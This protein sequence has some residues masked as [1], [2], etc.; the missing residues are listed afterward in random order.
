MAGKHGPEGAVYE[1]QV[2]PAVRKALRKMDPSTRTGILRV[3]GN[4][5]AIPRP[6]GVVQLKDR[7]GHLRLRIGDYRVIYTVDDET[8]L[9]TVAVA[10]HRREVYR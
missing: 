10:G 7:R 9:V 1:V 6:L 4:L 8:R 3:I 2:L 5:R